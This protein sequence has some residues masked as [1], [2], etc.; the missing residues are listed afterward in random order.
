MSVDILVIEGTVR[1]ERYSIHVAQDVTELLNKHDDVDAELFDMDEY[2]IPLLKTRTYTPG[3][4]PDDVD[5]F[6]QKVEHADGLLIVSP[7]YNH[8]MPGA[9]KNLLDY[10]YPEYEDKPFSYVTVSRGPFG[11]VRLQEDL[12]RFTAVVNGITGPSQPVTFVRDAYTKEGEPLD[13]DNTERLES[14]IPDVVEHTK[15]YRD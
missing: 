7:E 11:G 8:T 9:L 3:E 4:V 15:K 6:R 2:D 13:E 5:L 12:Y 10:L 14:F 1:E